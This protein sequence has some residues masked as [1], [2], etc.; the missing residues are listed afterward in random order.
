MK[1]LITYALE[2]ERG[3][4]QIPGHE[5]FFCKT[6]VGKV[7]AALHTYEQ[8][9]NIKPDL[10]LAVGTAGTIHHRVGDIVVADQFVDRDLEKI[11]HLGVPFQLDFTDE[12]ATFSFLQ[13]ANGTVSTG[14]T[15]QENFDESS[16][17]KWADVFDMEAFG[18]AQACKMLGIPFVAVKYITD[19]IGQNSIKHWE[20]KLEDAKLALEEFLKS[21][22]QESVF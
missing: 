15:F 8:I 19:V 7:A 21:L 22:L 5:L 10:V 9:L 6:G 18:G 2:A 17:G 20:D 13:N 14:D 16:A 1:I 4:W 12:L 3:N 11:A